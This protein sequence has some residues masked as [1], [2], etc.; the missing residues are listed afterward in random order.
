MITLTTGRLVQINGV[1]QENDTQGV[2][3]GFAVEFLGNTATFNLAIGSGAPSSFNIAVYNLPVAI[4]VNLGSGAW[5]S[6][7]GFSGT[8]GA[9]ALANFVAQ[10]KAVRNT[11]ESFVAGNSVMPGTQVAWT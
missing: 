6:T 11:V 2:N 9:G 7:N 1:T 3:T 10:T 8:I 5:T 4:T